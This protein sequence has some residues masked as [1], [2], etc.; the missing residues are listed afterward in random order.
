APPRVRHV[1]PVWQDPPAPA[2][3]AAGAPRVL[4]SLSTTRF[5]GQ[6]KTLQNILDAMGKLEAEVIVTTG[7]TI[8]PA[9]LR[10]PGNAAVV[11]HRDHGEVLPT[12]SLVIGH[13]GHSTTARALAHGIPLL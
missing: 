7:P 5:P 1:G 8:A 11:R 6:D 12:T 4:V 13:G 3:P 9:T 10:A 2:V